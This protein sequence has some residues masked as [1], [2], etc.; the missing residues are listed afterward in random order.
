V[1][2]NLELAM[3]ADKRARS[4][5]F[6]RLGSAELDRIADTLALVQL[7]DA[8]DRPAGLLSH[9]QKQWLEIGMLLMQEPRLILL[10]EP[11]AGMTD[12][13]TM[14]TAEL[15]LTLA[16]RHSVVVVEHDMEFVGRIARKVTV[17]H[18]GQV[19]AEGPLDAVSADP[20]VIEV[21]LG[22]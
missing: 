17:L 20:R 9:G 4:T 19:L 2:D 11:V 13:E 7:G 6:A 1:F 12:E 3:T 21:Y 22:R 14:R 8:F 18:E 16:G 10:D 15:C 5:L